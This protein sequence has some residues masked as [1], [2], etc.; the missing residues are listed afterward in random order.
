MPDVADPATLIDA[1]IAEELSGLSRHLT[2]AGPDAAA[3]V[4]GA[5]RAVSGGKRL[6]AL[7]CLASSRACGAPATALTD[8]AV[9]SA[10]ALEFF[11]AAALTHDDLMDGSDTRRGQPSAHRWFS[12]RVPTLLDAGRAARFGA[13]GAILVGDLLLATSSSVLFRAVRDLPA[14]VVAHTTEIFEAMAAEV[15]LGQYLDLVAAHAPWSDGSG[16]ELAWRVIT[17]KTARY[18]VELPLTLGARLAGAPEETI[19]WLAELGRHVGI[20]F[21]LRDDVLGVFGDPAVTGKPAGDD[22]REG[23]RTVLI[24]L[25][26]QAAGDGDRAL[27]ER[28]LGRRDLDP[29][30]AHALREVLVSTG[31]RDAV[32]RLIA[33]HAE[34]ARLRL[35][36]PP[37]EIGSLEEIE[38]LLRSAVDRVA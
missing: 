36:T 24:A 29:E 4:E 16:L 19:A 3:L 30:G 18:S 22:L 37:A 31:A 11:Q 8:P 7:L 1:A 32:E 14:D 26:Y 35:A 5:E 34:A 9:R 2:V 13:A 17:A 25:A 15:A 21:Q 20:A 28:D 27:L 38:G 23:K 33:E 12:A 6:R 10:A